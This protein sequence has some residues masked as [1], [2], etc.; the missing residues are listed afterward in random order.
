M[1]DQLGMLGRPD[2]TCPSKVPGPFRSEPSYFDILSCPNPNPNAFRLYG[3]TEVTSRLKNFVFIFQQSS[4]CTKSQI[5]FNED[6]SVCPKKPISAA[7]VTKQRELRGNVDKESKIKVKKQL[8]NAKSKEL[9][10]NDIFG[11][12]EISS[13]LSESF[14]KLKSKDMDQG[15]TVP[16][17]TN[18]SLLKSITI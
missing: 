12:P 17:K 10:G 7:E 1:V 13:K 3:V 5:S 2:R 18:A 14:M 6:E 11:P 9:N 4:T 8:S 16:T 15:N